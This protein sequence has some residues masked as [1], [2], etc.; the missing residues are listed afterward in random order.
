MN[1]DA[2]SYIAVTFSPASPFLDSPS[3]LGEMYP[4]LF[5]H[6][7]VGEL[8]DVH[9]YSMPNENWM[10]ARD[11]VLGGLNGHDGVLDVEEQIPRQRVKRGGDEL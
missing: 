6:G 8:S 3:S 7:Q 10:D 2:N 11:E 1:H 5:Y 9:L 4:G